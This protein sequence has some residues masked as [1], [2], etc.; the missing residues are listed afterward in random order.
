MDKL[1]MR[2]YWLLT[3]GVGL[4]YG[5]LAALAAGSILLPFVIGVMQRSTKKESL[6]TYDDEEHMEV[7]DGINTITLSG[8]MKDMINPLAITSSKL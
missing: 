8:D 5:F 1:L 4:F 6:G 3:I 2:S 7:M